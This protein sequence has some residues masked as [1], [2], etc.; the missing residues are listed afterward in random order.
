MSKTEFD[1]SS[2]RAF[3][4]CLKKK[5]KAIEDADFISMHDLPAG[6][7][8]SAD[9]DPKSG[10]WGQVKIC[11]GVARKNGIVAVRNTNDPDKE[12]VLFSAEEW[13]TF[14]SGVKAG[15]FG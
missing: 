6:T 11:V 12:T 5:F 1:T 3:K 2:P 7:L 10:N 15:V 9:P 8:D 4:N 14:V 13:E